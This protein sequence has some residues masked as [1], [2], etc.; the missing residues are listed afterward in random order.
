MTKEKD[1]LAT[2][3][4]NILQKLNGQWS[5]TDTRRQKEKKL[6]TR[7]KTGSQKM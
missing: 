4:L 3:L 1:K 5:G 2:V 7:K 6:G